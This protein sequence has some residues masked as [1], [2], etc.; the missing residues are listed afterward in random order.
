MTDHLPAARP[1]PISAASYLGPELGAAYDQ[2][3]PWTDIV[4]A[5]ARPGNARFVTAAILHLYPDLTLVDVV[6]VIAPVL[7]A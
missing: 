2:G 4:A 1:E 6:G 7:A 3:A 5:L